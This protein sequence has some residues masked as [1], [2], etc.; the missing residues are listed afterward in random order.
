MTTLTL[1]GPA[2]ARELERYLERLLRYDRRAAVRL[3]ADRPVLEV[4]GRPPFEVVCVRAL[5]LA[6]PA[7]LD[8]TV[9]AGELLDGI[10]ADAAEVRVPRHL[11]AIAW[12]GVLPPRA[13]WQQVAEAPAESVVR[14]VVRGVAAF[15]AQTERLPE[16]QR[17]RAVLDRVAAEVW[18]RPLLAGVPLRA[19]HA[20]HAL[21][22]LAPGT[23]VLVHHSA[24]WFRLDGRYGSVALRRP[25]RPEL[26]LA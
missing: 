20:A 16:E 13:G 9:S 15:R 12:A 21:G 19:A 1:A 22:F 24:G 18:A 17:T 26:R 25:G 14:A 23:P 8:T 5:P 2:E 6:V 4:F 10:A 3:R 7:D 11:A